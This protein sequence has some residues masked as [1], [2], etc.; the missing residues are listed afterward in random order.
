MTTDDTPK[1]PPYYL[2]KG[3][4][5]TNPD[6]V[7][8]MA[9]WLDEQA[10]QGYRLVDRQVLGQGASSRMHL[11]MERSATPEVSPEGGA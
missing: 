7:Q 3:F 10:A 8:S 2:C 6:A 4:S 1:P 11:V 9:D 5:A